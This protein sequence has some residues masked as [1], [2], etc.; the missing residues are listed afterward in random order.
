MAEQVEAL[1]AKPGGLCS[2][3]DIHRAETQSHKI[4]L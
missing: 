3:P 4:V 1:V 2:L